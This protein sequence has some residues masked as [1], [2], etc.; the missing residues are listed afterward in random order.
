M[1]NQ[2]CFHLLLYDIFRIYLIQYLLFVVFPYFENYIIKNDN[3][4]FAIRVEK[5]VV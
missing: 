4:P 2:T 3:F 1:T 5:H